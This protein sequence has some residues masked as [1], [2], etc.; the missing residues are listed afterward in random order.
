M[1]LG[2][3]FA[4]LVVK[5][6][7][8]IMR[9][10]IVAVLIISFFSCNK[11]K[12][13]NCDGPELDCSAIR[14]LLHAFNFDFRLTDKSTG[15]DLVFGTNPRYTDADIRLYADVARSVTIPLI[16]DNTKKLIQS[17][18]SKEEMYL[19]IKNTDVYKLTAEFRAETCC[20]SRV[21]TLAV[22]GQSI[23]TCCSD[24]ISFSVN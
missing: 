5:F 23:C 21:K 24:V 20:S 7:N 6:K 13:E 3:V 10:V 15:A 17:T 19:V 2:N 4:P 14:C 16:F 18:F 22:D 8:I 1:N 11:T 9:F 12:S